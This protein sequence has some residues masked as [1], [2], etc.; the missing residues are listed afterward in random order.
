M[1]ETR[2]ID[3][4]HSQLAYRRVGTGPDV[5]FIH[6][7]PL[8]SATFRH[9]VPELSA[10]FTCHLFDLPGTGESTWTE[11]RRICMREHAKTVRSAIDAI[12]L[13]RYAMIAHD[14]G[15]LIARL[16]AA[17]DPDRVS[18]LVL[19][20]T[21]VPAHVPWQVKVY[22]A[23]AN[24]P[25][26]SAAL[27]SMLRIGAVRRSALGFGGCFRDPHFVDGEFFDLFV[28]PLLESKRVAQGQ[29]LLAK[30]I[31]LDM[32]EA[33]PA[34]HA[35]IPA[36]VRLIWG[37]ED[38]FFPIDNARQMLK[39]LAGPADLVEIEGAKLFA[40]EEFPKRFAQECR[41]F[42]CDNLPNRRSCTEAGTPS[43]ALRESDAVE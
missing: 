40:H 27:L 4:G 17:G 2:F 6:G 42:L 34:L 22:V 35:K 39:Q 26:G 37:P 5:V 16:V 43:Q 29:M 11:P 23:L 7:W 14:S 31:E 18:A 21:E 28:R 1:N 41:Q 19:G 24:V 12:G 30:N 36:P 25:L 33:M 20:N 8:H 10:D 13:E 32:A 3:V 38:P 9:I 15:G